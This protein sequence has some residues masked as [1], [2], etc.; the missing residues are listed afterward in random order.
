MLVHPI[1]MPAA[2][3]LTTA[4]LIN[5]STPLF[6]LFLNPQYRFPHL[7]HSWRI[8]IWDALLFIIPTMMEIQ[9]LRSK[10]FQTQHTNKLAILG[11]IIHVHLNGFDITPLI[12]VVILKLTTT[13]DFTGLW[14][15]LMVLS[16]EQVKLIGF[17]RITNLW[18]KNQTPSL[19][20]FWQADEVHLHPKKTDLY[21]SRTDHPTI[22]RLLHTVWSLRIHWIAEFTL[23]YVPVNRHYGVNGSL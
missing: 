8:I 5:P 12:I 4:L 20:C 15:V 3:P 13:M 19:V 23:P 11:W 14:T 21:Q 10:Y 1:I 9:L 17:Y 6:I 2:L 18:A 16:S 7:P 22:W